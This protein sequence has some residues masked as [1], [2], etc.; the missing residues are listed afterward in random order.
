MQ[1]LSDIDVERTLP[2]AI[3]ASLSML[4]MYFSG[5]IILAGHCHTA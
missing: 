5:R 2:L 3:A 1:A 4:L